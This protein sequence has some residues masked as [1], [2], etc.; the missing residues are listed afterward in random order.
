[1]SFKRGKKKVD[2]Y[3]LHRVWKKLPHTLKSFDL[4]FVAPEGMPDGLRQYHRDLSAW[5]E[6][7]FGRD[8]HAPNVADV[9]KIGGLTADGW[10]REML[11]RDGSRRL[12]LVDD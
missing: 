8:P 12:A 5:L 11:R 4:Y 1:M 2:R 7:E 10:Y 6:R 9:M 3:D